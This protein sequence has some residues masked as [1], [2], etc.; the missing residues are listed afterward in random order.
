MPSPYNLTPPPS[1]ISNPEPHPCTK[2]Y[3]HSGKFATSATELIDQHQC[4]KVKVG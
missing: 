3:T 4:L 2:M 1:I